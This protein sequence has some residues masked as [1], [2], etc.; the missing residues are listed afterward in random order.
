[1]ILTIDELVKVLRDNVNVQNTESDVID[2]YFLAMS[3]E[4]LLLYIKLGV[5][6]AYPKIT[7][8]EDLPDG[9]DYPIILLAK[10]ELYTKLATIRADKVDLTAD[11][12]NQ[13]KL[14]QRFTHYM[15]LVS[16]AKEQY[17][18]WVEDEG[19]GTVE[20][21]DLLINKKHYTNRNYELTPTPKIKLKFGTIATDSVE[22]YWSVSNTTLFGRYKVY[23]STSPIVDMF[24]EGHKLSDKIS[25]EAKLIKST[26]DI[27][28][29][30]HRVKGLEPDTTYYIAVASIER[31]SVFGY[32]EKTFTTLDELPPEEDVNIEEV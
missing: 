11:N 3:D 27:K 32:T 24:K 20:C 1:M 29:C 8:L 10:I 23:F 30:Y 19:T 21:H 26:I 25:S 6:R 13:L 5:S 31:N 12:N 16:Q 22:F 17:D 9:S 14:G 2:E 4:D 28:D 7:D 18:Q 15:T